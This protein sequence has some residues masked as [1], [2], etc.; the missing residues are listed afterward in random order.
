MKQP[1]S[2]QD[3][4]KEVPCGQQSAAALANRIGHQTVTCEPED[5]DRFGHVVAVCRAGGNDLNAWMVR[6]GMALAYRRFSNDYVRQEKKA[7][8]EK[9]GI[10][11]GWFVKPW[12]WRRGRRLTR[13]RVFEENVCAIKGNIT[14]GGKRIYHIPGGKYYGP[15]RIDPPIGERYFCTE[16]EARAA[17]W[18]KSKR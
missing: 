10:W 15:A 16:A 7:A 8:K 17:G 14:R 2:S 1:P 3:R 6:Q 13:E 12:D 5:R 11:S 9:A 4:G 18:R